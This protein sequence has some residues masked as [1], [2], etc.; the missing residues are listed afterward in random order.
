MGENIEIAYADAEKV[1]EGN[2]V[3][4]YGAIY[5]DR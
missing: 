3:S 1:G 5:E 4:F 2:V